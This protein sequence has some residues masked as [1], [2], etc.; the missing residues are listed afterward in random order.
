MTDDAVLITGGAGY[1]GS[2]TVLA[3][4]EI[5]R[6][7]MVL[8]NLSKGSRDLVPADVPF[9]EGDAGDPKLLGD[10]FG[11]HRIGAVVHFA[12]DIVVPES[13]AAPLSYYLSNTRSDEHTSELQSLMRN[14]YAVFSFK[15]K[16][17]KTQ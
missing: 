16:K 3:C 10:I 1:I 9:Y 12:G 6:P 17:K 15:K 13:V 8:D 5:P 7:V 2:H 11:K 14:S 4:R